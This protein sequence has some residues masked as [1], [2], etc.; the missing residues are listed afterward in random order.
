MDSR[1]KGFHNWEIGEKGEK[2]AEKALYKMSFTI[3]KFGGPINESPFNILASRHHTIPIRKN[4]NCITCGLF[5][6]DLYAERGASKWFIDVK[7]TEQKREHGIH[8]TNRQCRFGFALHT[9]GYNIGILRIRIIKKEG[10]EIIWASLFKI[11]SRFFRNLFDNNS[12]IDFNPPK[13]DNPIPKQQFP[14]KRKFM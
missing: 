9:L 5:P 2:I 13:K 12:K 4:S 6:F 8:L 3:V 10:K 14:I 7:T 1:E 11:P